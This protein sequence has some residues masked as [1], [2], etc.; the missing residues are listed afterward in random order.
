MSTLAVTCSHLLPKQDSRALEVIFKRE[1]YS[2][3]RMCLSYYA[4]AE[5]EFS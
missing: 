1:R 5:A 3:S 4:Q 2:S